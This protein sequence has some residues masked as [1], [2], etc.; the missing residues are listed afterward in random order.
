MKLA[1]RPTRNTHFGAL[2]AAVFG[3]SLLLAGPV[4]AVV[5][6]DKPLNL[7]F[8]G[9]NSNFPGTLQQS[10]D[11]VQLGAAA[12]VRRVE[13]YG[14]RGGGVDD[15]R[16]RF[17]TGVAENAVTAHFYQDDVIATV[18]DTGLD[19]NNND[20]FFYTADITDVNLLASTRY[21]LSIMSLEAST[22]TWLHSDNETGPAAL[23]YHRN[24][25]ADDWREIGST[26]RN[27]QAFTLFS[28]RRSVPEPT[29]LMLLGLGL[30]GLGFARQRRL[31]D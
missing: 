13:W 8:F 11:D 26:G 12:T 10:T 19:H 6:L 23:M 28:D 18:V 5:I 7:T 14:F 22:W 27:S 3:V 24:G 30:A 2:A 9:W 20:V 29:T 4:Q 16:I 21:E 15:F 17:F 25:D 1:V 31:T